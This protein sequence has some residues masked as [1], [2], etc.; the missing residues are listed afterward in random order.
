M[1]IDQMLE[2]ARSLEALLKGSPELLAFATRLAEAR[3]P[4]IILENDRLIRA[5]EAASILGVNENTIGRYVR[6]GILRAYSVPGCSHR[7][8][9]LSEVRQ[10]PKRKL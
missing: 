8:F 7:K 2:K 5:G 4:V 9:R 3:D 1:D 10:L 6:D